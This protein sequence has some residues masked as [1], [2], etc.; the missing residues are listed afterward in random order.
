[1]VLVAYNNGMVTIMTKLVNTFF[2]ANGRSDAGFKN[3]IFTEP[4]RTIS[5]ERRP[6]YQP[7]IDY[8]DAQSLFSSVTKKHPDF[9][10]LMLT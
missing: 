3:T 1:M 7:H 10:F 9:N 4:E 5:K 6:A 2:L 8:D